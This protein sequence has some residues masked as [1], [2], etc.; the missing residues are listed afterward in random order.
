[1][2]RDRDVF[3]QRLAA[4]LEGWSLTI[5]QVQLDRLVRH[6]ELMVEAN[7]R[8]NL[9]RITDPQ[10]AALLH[11]ADSLALLLWVEARPAARIT[12]LD[13]GTGAG[14][15]AVPLAVLGPAWQVTA[16][17]STRKKT[18]FV[19]QAAQELGLDNLEVVHAR[20][21]HW[22]P[23]REFQIIAL[24]AVSVVKTALEKTAHLVAPKGYVVCYKT[25]PAAEQE[26][27]TAAALARR[28]GLVLADQV[29]YTLGAEVHPRRL[30]IYQKQ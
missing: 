10:E 30:V 25:E 8:V 18:A 4:A 6:Y 24:R 27:K 16:M 9:T 19:D 15:P 29:T 12:L 28:V 3:T 7:R 2:T 1:M 26:I 22:H 13:V 17:D 14:F 21:E 23:Q 20:A 5:T 11:Y